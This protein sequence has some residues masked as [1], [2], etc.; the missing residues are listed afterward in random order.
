MRLNLPFTQFHIL[1]VDPSAWVDE[2]EQVVHTELSGKTV[3]KPAFLKATTDPKDFTFP[4]LF[5][6]FRSTL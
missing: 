2:V 6:G 5:N 1:S 4:L 3:A